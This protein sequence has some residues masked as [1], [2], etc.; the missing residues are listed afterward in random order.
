M[1][2]YFPLILKMADFHHTIVS[3]YAAAMVISATTTLAAER[4]LL[5]E[6]IFQ[7]CIDVCQDSDPSV[8]KA[9][10]R[11]FHNVIPRLQHNQHKKYLFNEVSIP[12]YLYKYS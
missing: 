8:R 3:R 7:A 1:E 2:K 12:N 10:L 11:N 6:A 9:S 4:D 5:T